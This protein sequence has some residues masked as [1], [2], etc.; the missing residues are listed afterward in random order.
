VPLAG[1][2]STFR[3]E[4]LGREVGGDFVTPRGPTREANSDVSCAQVEVV[5]ATYPVRASSWYSGF[6]DAAIARRTSR[7]TASSN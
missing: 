3:G 6:G 1:D 2:V 5:A 7:R 4:G